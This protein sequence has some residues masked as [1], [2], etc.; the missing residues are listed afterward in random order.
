MPSLELRQPLPDGAESGRHFLSGG[1]EMGRLIR[2]K[3][4]AST[5]LGPSARWPQ[6]LRSAV[7][8]L[9]P[10]RAQICL[11][12]GPDLV[13]IYNDAYRPTL[14]VKHP[15]ALGQPARVVW[16][17]FWED[18]LRPLLER[19]LETGEAFWASD[20]PF[21][22]ER[23]GYPEETYFD[24]SYD[25]VRDESGGVG[26]VFCIVSETTGRVVGERRLRTL[27][28]L[29]RIA[30][31][32]RTVDDVFSQAAAV[33]G[34]NRHDLP[35]AALYQRRAEGPAR[36]AAACGVAAESGAEWPL[37]EAPAAEMVLRHE[38]LRPFAPLPGGLWPEPARTAVVL[39]IVTAGRPPFGDLVAG[40]SPRRELDESYR[41]FLRLAASS[42][43]AAL[44]A[45]S[46]LEEERRR[47]EALAE[48]DRAKTAFFSNVSH[49]F[50]TPL[51][52]MLGP[53][54]E[55]LRQAHGALPEGVGAELEVV[56][57]N[58][59]RLLKLVNTLLDF[60][61]LEAGRVQAAYEPT[62]LAALTADLA[63][64]F[65]SAVE[66]AGMRLVV[67]CPRLD[68]PVFVDPDMWEK[69][70]LNLLSNAFKFTL[71]G[72]IE[73]RLRARDRF[74]EL[75]VRD[76][77]VGIQPAEIPRL[78]ERFY[79][80]AEA[81]GRTHE[82]SGIGLALVQ[83]LVRLHGGTV[84]VE[85]AAGAGTAFTVSV[86]LGS[87]HLP[88]ER[89]GARRSLAGRGAGARVFVQ[90]A[91]RW[92]P[93]PDEPGAGMPPAPAAAAALASPARGAAAPRATGRPRVLLADDNADM[94]AYVR[95]L[96]AERFDVA[97]VP[98]GQAALAAALDSVPDLVLADV[99]MPGMNG[100]ELLR[101]LR[102]DART[103]EVPVVLLSARAGE[104][105][106]VAALAA[107]ADDYL[108][109]PFRAKELLARVEAHAQ[110]S[111]LRRNAAAA[112]RESEELFRSLCTC[113]PVGIF[114]TDPAG[115]STYTNPRCQAI[116]GFSDADDLAGERWS[117]FVHPE[118]RQRVLDDW[119]RT[120]R[121]G[122]EFAAEFRWQHG[123]GTIRWTQVRSSPIQAE[124]GRLL[125]HVGT[126]EDIT[127]ARQAAAALRAADRRKDEFLAVL[128]HELRNPLAPIRNAVELMRHSLDEREVLRRLH[129]VL[130]RQLAHLV[131]IVDD[132]LDISRISR[133][134]M[135][136][137]RERVELAAVM[138]GAVEAR[139]DPGAVARADAAGRRPRAPRAGVLQSAQ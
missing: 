24:V 135:D 99:M 78:F 136:L 94:R 45:A 69:I 10:S 60:S 52:L 31:E 44:A 131:R 4:W 34:A 54:E 48:I 73:V 59:E 15:E 115:S 93:E 22:L 58:G 130:E 16:C 72:E 61:R 50:R 100:L 117:A 40:V 103:R 104:E 121:E 53:L 3:D 65:R 118:D 119:S 132:L 101:C 127:E 77:G 66:R 27:R 71:A 62:D 113:S 37:A 122:R 138:Q 30:G 83:E 102:Q 56:R 133:D 109:K 134:K 89:I 46:V 137:R 95:R 23:H 49:E 28:D 41:D 29:G 33:M 38:R 13:A 85:S 64:A 106:G 129:A 17:E 86:P 39:P 74:A 79:R 5:A 92:L 12:W 68:E 19:V 18:V 20:H 8:I 14:G 51:T 97:A 1:G 126:V 55:I 67:D 42:L 43:A 2:G 112:L 128:A 26:G 107:G 111:A 9:L 7:S 139:V 98:D 124:D 87:S 82:G 123:D 88:G 47:A 125:G 35:F 81:Q 63:S 57:R 91:M 105:A 70:V 80:G 21:F 32:A 25:P 36:L 84:S 6:S 110:L 11:F 75:S 76:T 90:E 114:M 120:A 116:C 96:L 108:V